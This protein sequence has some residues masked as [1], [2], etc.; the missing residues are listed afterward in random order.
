MFSL[1]IP[2]FLNLFSLFKCLDHSFLQS[3]PLVCQT[4]GILRAVVMKYDVYHSLHSIKVPL[5]FQITFSGYVSEYVIRFPNRRQ[6]YVLTILQ[7]LNPTNEV[8]E[9]DLHVSSLPDGFSSLFL[10][11]VLYLSSIIYGPLNTIDKIFFPTVDPSFPHL[12]SSY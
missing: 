9:S 11:I 5:E 3:L 1:V 12:F 8:P 4:K 10:Q 7:T 2:G 6:N